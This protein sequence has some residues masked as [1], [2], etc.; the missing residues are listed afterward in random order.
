MLAFVLYVIS[1]SWIGYGSV[2]MGTVQQASD[3]AHTAAAIRLYTPYMRISVHPGQTITYSVD[4]MNN[5]K[6]IKNVDLSVTGLPRGWDHSLKSGN[7]EVSQIAILPNQKETIT[8]QVTVPLRVNKGIY[9]FYLHAGNT[10]VLPLTVVVAQRGVYKT[11]FTTDQPNLEGAA[12]STFTF[13]TNLQNA[14]A[15][16]QLYALDAQV[17]PGWDIAFKAN[18]YKQV[19]SVLVG[20]NATQNL[21]IEVHPPDQVPAGTY[22]IPVMASS[23]NTGAELELAV[24]ITGNYGMSLST[25]S[26]LLSTDVTAGSQKTLK[27]TVTNTGS[28]SLKKIT[29]NAST[30]TN[31][32]VTFDP[33]TIDELPPGKT[34]DLRATIKADKHAIAGDYLVTIRASTQ[35]TN[36]KAD[37]RVTVKT[38]M[39]WGWVGV[40]IILIALGSIYYLFRKY[41]RR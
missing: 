13:N 19:A 28:A 17:P 8:L 35:E 38:P 18:G 33:K 41:G 22:K 4:V 20:P 34:A 24:T 32:D 21:T 7:W 6:T 3:T 26:G 2:S 9:R 29:F 14:T 27:I 10:V 39:I 15:D 12:N 31:W 25:P 16:T 5:T 11:A 37:F 30:P 36:A 23:G 40:L 1:L